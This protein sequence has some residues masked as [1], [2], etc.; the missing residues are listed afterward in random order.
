[1]E[2]Q[3]TG[4][5]ALPPRTSRDA[6]MA[7]YL[8]LV[9]EQRRAASSPFPMSRDRARHFSA[10]KEAALRTYYETLPRLPL[11]RCP[12]CLVVL[13]RTIDPWGVDGFWWHD[14]LA[15]DLPVEPD[16]PHFRVLTGAL[17]L[18]NQRVQGGRDEAFP[19]PGVPYVVP[20]VLSLDTMK[21]VIASFM[22]ATGHRAFPIA[23]FSLQE[24]PVA[25]LTQSWG[26]RSYSFRDHQGQP[27]FMYD[28]SPWDFDLRPWIRSGKVAWISDNDRT[29]ALRQDDP[30][31][32]PYV[33]LPGERRPQ[34][35]QGN[36]VRTLPPPDGHP[37]NP[38]SE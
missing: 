20:R 30:A 4:M 15:L 9:D 24:P 2:L 31:A 7:R 16:C 28:T 10:A 35:I 5:S 11:S 21:A 14:K 37:V 32:C 38:F 19:G 33:D 26:R 12:H 29:L 13:H 1:M 6:A 23:Y 8:D 27:G 18:R 22:L 25:G 3:S 34:V 36:V 17:D